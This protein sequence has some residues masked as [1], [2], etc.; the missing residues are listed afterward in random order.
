MSKPAFSP[1]TSTY[2][3]CEEI[4][5]SKQLF[6]K[7]LILLLFY[8]KRW[9]LKCESQN[10]HRSQELFMDKIGIVLY[11]FQLP[12][13]LKLVG[14]PRRP[15]SRQSHPPP[16]LFV[17]SQVANE[18]NC[19]MQKGRVESSVKVGA[20]GGFRPTPRNIGV[21]KREQTIY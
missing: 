3:S 14:W 12:C 7:P 13:F 20:E 6:Q 8:F 15:F 9:V 21:Q 2:Y 1:Y 11:Y 19:K 18:L 5:E 16:H 17:S 4:K 10:Q